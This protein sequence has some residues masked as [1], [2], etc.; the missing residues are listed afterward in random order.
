MPMIDRPPMP[1]LGRFLYESG[2]MDKK[3][4]IIHDLMWWRDSE[5]DS[6]N[7]KKA[8]TIDKVL[9]RRLAMM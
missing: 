2:D 5:V 7:F 1:P 6:G 3:S 9:N 4:M 8:K